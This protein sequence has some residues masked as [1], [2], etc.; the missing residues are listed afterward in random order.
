[1]DLRAASPPGVQTGAAGPEPEQG[2][3]VLGPIESTPGGLSTQT[4][5]V[6]GVVPPEV[7]NK[8]GIKVIPKLRTGTDLE[9]GIELRV[10]VG[11]AGASALASDLRQI[12]AELGLSASVTV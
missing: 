1:A 8:L 12:L 9:L 11:Q 6:R 10:R 7:W 5:Q 2:T 3:T 4:I